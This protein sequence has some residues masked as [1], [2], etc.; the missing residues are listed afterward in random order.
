M[1]GG[2]IFIR[3]VEEQ[4]R[5]P[6]DTLVRRELRTGQEDKSCVKN[7]FSDKV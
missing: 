4:E 6:P 7:R 2:G 5:L 1:Y 3:G